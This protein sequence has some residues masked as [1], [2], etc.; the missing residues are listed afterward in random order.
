MGRAILVGQGGKK[1]TGLATA[2]DVLN[3]ITFSNA[4]AADLKG[5]M[6]AGEASVSPDSLK[7]WTIRTSAADNSWRSVCYGNGLFVAVASIGTGNRVM[8][9]PDGINWTTRTSVVDNSWRSVCYGNGLF[10]AVAINGVGNRVM[11]SPDGINWTIRT[12]AA[13]NSW[14]SVCYGNG[15]FV[16][17]AYSG[18]GNRV[19]TSPDGIN[20]TI[21]TSAADNP[22][23][24]VCYGNGLFVAVANTGTGNR[25]MT[26][27]DGIN[28][29]IRTS[30]ADNTWY[31]VC[32][33]NGLFVAVADT[34]AGNRVM[35]ADVVREIT[36]ASSK[37]VIPLGRITAT[38][39]SA[40]V[41]TF[42]IRLLVPDASAL[43]IENFIVQLTNLNNTTTA[44]NL[45]LT[46]TYNS[47]TGVITCTASATLFTTGSTAAN[48]YVVL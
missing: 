33:G 14:Y 30:A 20:W 19:M 34:G 46:W 6:W 13:D 35:T 47:A 32:Y 45:T 5:E 22:W 16:A 1:R 15:L 4:A 2:R 43:R 23:R 21:R 3:G 31:F 48:I 44:G 39:V 17:V 25:V 7:P 24:S 37:V 9:S 36:P 26:S 12:S 11:T 10:V 18:V 41:V 40:T 8:T 28:W 27:P 38:F 29:T 42:N